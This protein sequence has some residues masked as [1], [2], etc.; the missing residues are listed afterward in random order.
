MRAPVYPPLL[1]L[2]PP[3]MPPLLPIISRTRA[4]GSCYSIPPPSC[5]MHQ[6]RNRMRLRTLVAGWGSGSGS[7]RGSRASAT[8]SIVPKADPSPHPVSRHGKIAP[9]P[10]TSA[11][12][13]SQVGMLARYGACGCKRRFLQF[14]RFLAGG[15]LPRVKKLADVYNQPIRKRKPFSASAE[16]TGEDAH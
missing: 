16:K 10:R 3:T 11:S 14:V 15:G 1:Y 2:T 8:P 9:V 12:A 5:T 6:I 4:C 13:G 7:G